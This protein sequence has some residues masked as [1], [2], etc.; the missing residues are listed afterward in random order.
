MK[1]RD[2]AIDLA[3]IKT[4][5]GDNQVMIDSVLARF[6]ATVPKRVLALSLPPTA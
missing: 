5:F 1:E 6:V 3:V 2:A 4:L